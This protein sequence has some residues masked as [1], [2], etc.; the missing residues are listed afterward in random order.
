MGWASLRQV[1]WPRAQGREQHLHLLLSPP[2]AAPG[3]LWRLPE[4]QLEAFGHLS[5]LISCTGVG[6]SPSTLGIQ[7]SPLLISQ[8]GHWVL[9]Q[10]WGED[11]SHCPATVAEGSP[12]SLW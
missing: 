10:V 5:G 7:W 11:C 8:A 2:C 12:L 9:L 4:E 1:R 6:L 3:L